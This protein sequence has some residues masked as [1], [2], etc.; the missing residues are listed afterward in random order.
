MKIFAEVI[1]TT[2]EL[3]A[4][5][6]IEVRSHTYSEKEFLAKIKHPSQSAD[7]VHSKGKKK[8]SHISSL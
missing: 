5:T 1:K 7:N 4:D 3:P 2:Y 6:K 8:G